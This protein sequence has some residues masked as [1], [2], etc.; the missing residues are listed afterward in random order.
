MFSGPFLRLYSIYI[1][2]FE[3]MSKFYDECL[4]KY[5]NFAKIVTEFESLP[6][7]KN[8]KIK[9]YLLKVNIQNVL[10]YPRDSAMQAL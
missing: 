10:A 8:L 2:D 7:C 3:A 5:P 9:H 1:R 4:V 6:K